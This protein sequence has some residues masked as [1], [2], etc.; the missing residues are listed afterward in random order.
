MYTNTSWSS[1]LPFPNPGSPLISRRFF[2]EATTSLFV[3]ST[4][5]RDVTRR[6]M[7]L[8]RAIV[9]AAA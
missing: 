1:T 9:E 2:T 3:A 5:A 8:T 4:R 6:R 7:W